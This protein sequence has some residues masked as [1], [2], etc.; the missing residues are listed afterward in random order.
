MKTTPKA[1]N[2]LAPG[3]SNSMAKMMIV[4]TPQAP[5]QCRRQLTSRA[6]I[7]RVWMV[8]SNVNHW[9][10]WQTDIQKPAL[11]GPLQAGTSFD[12]R[13]GGAGIHSTLH[14]V[15]PYQQLGWT[16]KTYG[17]YAIHNWTFLP[18]GNDTTVIVEETMEGLLAR[19]FKGAFNKQLRQGMEH[20][21]SLLKAECERYYRGEKV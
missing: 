9:A 7:Q 8:L 21:L 13:T 5:V 18:E 11:H 3:L 16:G 20:W 19:L 10:D 14:T 1:A 6:N 12:W 15:R 2:Q 4:P 17:M